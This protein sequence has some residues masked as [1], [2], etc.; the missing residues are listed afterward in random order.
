MSRPVRI[1]RSD[2][3]LFSNLLNCFDYVTVL[4]N[5]FVAKLHTVLPLFGNVIISFLL[6]DDHL[7]LF[8]ENDI[9]VWDGHVITREDLP[10]SRAE[11][12]DLVNE[13]LAFELLRFY[14]PPRTTIA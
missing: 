10:G 8:L 13:Q 9:Q 2:L 14:T 11:L 6:D 3:A 5:H 12:E 1:M 7:S 4:D